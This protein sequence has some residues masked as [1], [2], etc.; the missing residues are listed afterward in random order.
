MHIYVYAYIYNFP[1]VS[2][3]IIRVTRVQIAADN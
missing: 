1:I 3:E 2:E